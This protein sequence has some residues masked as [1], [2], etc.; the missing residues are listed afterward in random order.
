MSTVP[1][2][3]KY[4]LIFCFIARA[5]HGMKPS[6]TKKYWLEERHCLILMALEPSTEILCNFED[7]QTTIWP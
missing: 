3:E 2:D 1:L 6:H 5:T 7:K 4:L